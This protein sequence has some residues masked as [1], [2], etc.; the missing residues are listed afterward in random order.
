LFTGCELL[1]FSKDILPSEDKDKL[2]N[3]TDFYILMSIMND[4]SESTIRNVSCAKQVLELIFPL[5]SVHLSQNKIELRD[6]ESYKLCGEINDFNF[7]EFKKI[8][9]QIF[10]LKRTSTEPEYNV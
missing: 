3:L 5:Y 9:E 6:R 2:F 10:C 4:K 7:L 1:K 8:I